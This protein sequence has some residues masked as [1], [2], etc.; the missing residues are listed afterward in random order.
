MRV[1]EK[2]KRHDFKNI[3]TFL[4]HVPLQFFVP[5]TF[6]YSLAGSTS[7]VLFSFFISISC[8]CVG[9]LVQKRR[10][11]NAIIASIYH[12]FVSWHSSCIGEL[13]HHSQRWSHQKLHI[14]NAPTLLREAWFK[15]SRPCTMRSLGTQDT[16]N[17]VPTGKDHKIWG[18]PAW[19][20]H[21]KWFLTFCNA[22][23]QQ[24]ASTARNCL[25]MQIQK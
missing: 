14:W 10:K 17:N 2:G 8:T 19:L 18:N 7:S 5:L 13:E 11:I 1:C 25:S 6:M 22:S 3:A 24:P 23:I 21:M 4:E 12:E 15:V 16:R 20:H 9:N